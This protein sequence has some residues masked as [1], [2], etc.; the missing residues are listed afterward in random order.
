MEKRYIIGI[1]EGTTSTRAILYDVINYKIVDKEQIKFEQ[2]FPF[3][4]WVEQDAADVYKKVEQTL[5]LVIKRNNLTKDNVFGIAIT[6]QRETVVA[7]DKR[8]GKPIYNAIGWQCKRTADFCKRIKNKSAIK[9]KT[10]LIVDSY[11]SASKINWLIKNCPEAKAL[12]KQDNLCFGTMDSYIIFKLTK[13]VSFVTDVTNASRTMLFNINTLCWDEKLLK[14]FRINPNCLPQVL[15]CNGEFGMAKTIVGEL[16]ILSVMGDQQAALFGHGCFEEGMVK[17]TYGTGCFVLLNT[18]DVPYTKNNKMLSTIAW[19]IDDK[20]TYALEGSVFNAGSAL[21]WGNRIGL[22]KD[23]SET[24]KLAQ[25]VDSNMGV[26]MVPAFNG[27]GAPY[28]NS[29]S[30]GIICGLTGGVSKAHLCRAI[31][32]SMA[33]STFDIIK[34]MENKNISIKEI[35]C[36]GGVSSNNFLL[37]FQSDLVCVKILRQE[38]SEVTAMGAIF[39]AGLAIGVFKDLEDIASHITFESEWMPKLNSASVNKLVNGWHKAVKKAI[40]N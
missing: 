26:Y 39:M 7:W 16:P 37:Q 9:S 27:L 1:D 24:D 30:R 40:N 6:N 5:N 22:F 31:L 38:S 34:A 3:P 4:G 8:N 14:Q 32:E 25:S 33:Y 20:V 13:G 15:P 21:E 12:E 19:A 28:W 10:G 2:I 23:A 35:R 11:F 36:D 18:A 29:S 17:A